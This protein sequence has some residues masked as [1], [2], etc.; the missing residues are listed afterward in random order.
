MEHNVPGGNEL[1]N[2]IESRRLTSWVSSLLRE[3]F[4]TLTADNGD[5]SNILP[6]V[7]D[8]LKELLDNRNLSA[9]TRSLMMIALIKGRDY[10]D[11]VETRNRRWENLTQ[12]ALSGQPQTDVDGFVWD[13]DLQAWVIL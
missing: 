9:E 7:L 8:E 11:E 13:E 10:L 6:G 12:H 3:V 2:I 1:D 5:P 4:I